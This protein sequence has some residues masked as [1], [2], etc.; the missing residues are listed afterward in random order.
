MKPKRI[1]ELWS[2]A[3]RTSFVDHTSEIQVF[4]RLI[5]E[6]AYR[7]CAELACHFCRLGYPLA[8]LNWHKDAAGHAHYCNAAAIRADR[9]EAFK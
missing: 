5:A 1:T 8:C 7:E 9:P 4:A 6:D 2:D 3:I